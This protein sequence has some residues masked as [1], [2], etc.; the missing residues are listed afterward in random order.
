MT[1]TDQVIYF[2]VGQSR[3]NQSIDSQQQWLAIVS[4]FSFATDS[5]FFLDEFKKKEIMIMTSF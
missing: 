3:D 1:V 5:L 2:L 4:K